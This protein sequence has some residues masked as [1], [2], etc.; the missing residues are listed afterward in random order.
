MKKT[1][2]V[3]KTYWKS[4]HLTI[5]ANFKRENP[6]K[7]RDKYRVNESQGLETE[8]VDFSSLSTFNYQQLIKQLEICILVVNIVNKRYSSFLTT[9]T[10]N[11]RTFEKVSEALKTDT[12]DKKNWTFWY[13]TSDEIRS[14]KHMQKFDNYYKNYL[15]FIFLLKD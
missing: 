7:K 3:K 1:W 15:I 9:F 4:N 11:T 10:S 13:A 8:P 2:S 12:Y 6:W 5:Q 14:Q